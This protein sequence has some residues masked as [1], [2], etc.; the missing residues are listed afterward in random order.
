[1]RPRESERKS[2]YFNQ[3]DL[4]HYNAKQKLEEEKERINN[5]YGINEQTYPVRQQSF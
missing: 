5:P 4:E 3:E 1:M 2:R